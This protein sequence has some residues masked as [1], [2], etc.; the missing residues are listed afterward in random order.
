MTGNGFTEDEVAQRA[1]TTPE[2]IRLLAELGILKPEDGTYPRR[3]VLRARFVL[4]S[5]RSGSTRRPSPVR[6]LQGI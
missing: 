4:V 1:G 6:L 3:D 2:R 5:M